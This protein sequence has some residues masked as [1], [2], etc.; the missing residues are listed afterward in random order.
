[1]HLDAGEEAV[2]WLRRSIEAN[3]NN[4]LSRF[5]LADALTRIGELNEAKATAQAAL[6]LDPTFTIRR[7]RATAPSNNPAFLAGRELFYR[8]SAA[9][10]G[11]G[12]LMSAMGLGC[13]KT[14]RRSIAIEEVIRPR[15]F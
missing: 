2:V 4:P 9:G 11:A 1:L 10:R 3:R 7:L 14:R 8:G 13:V 5:R 12:G 15:P 6:A